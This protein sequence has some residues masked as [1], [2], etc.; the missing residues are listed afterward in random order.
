MFEIG[1]KNTYVRQSVVDVLSNRHGV[2]G[3][4]QA[5]GDAEFL[6]HDFHQRRRT[7]GR[8][9]SARN[10]GHVLLV[11]VIVHTLDKH[12]RV[13]ARSADHHFFRARRDVFLIGCPAQYI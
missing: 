13:W 10:H 1:L 2:R 5:I 9:R 8:A 3:R 11:F 7:V 6:V 12:R 4:Q